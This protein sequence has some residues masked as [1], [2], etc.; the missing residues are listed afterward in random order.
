[1]NSPQLSPPIFSSKPLLI[2]LILFVLLAV[3]IRSQL[4][5]IDVVDRSAPDS[6]FS[7]QRAFDYL[8]ELTHEQLPHFVDSTNNQVVGERIIKILRQL[9]YQEEIQDQQI[10]RDSSRGLARCT[11]VK[12]ILVHIAGQDTSNGILLSAHYDSVPA[13]PGGSDAGAAVGTLL[14]IARLLRHSPKP[15]NSITL[16]FNEGEEFGLF[17]ARLFMEQHHL[18]KNIKLALNI[19][20][21]GSG[22]LSVMFETGE[23]SGWLVEHYASTTPKPLSSSLFYE[24]YKYLPNDTDLT[25][26][27]A[28]GLQ[29]LN[30]AHAEREPHYHTPLDNLENLDKGSLQHHGDN[31]W[32][33]LNALKDIDIAA[34]DSGNLVY[35]DILSMFVVSW[36]ESYSLVIASVLLLM[37][38]VLIY[39]FAKFQLFDFK[40]VAKSFLSILLVLVA[41]ALMGLLI[42]KSVV[43]FS[44]IATP[45]RSNGLSMQIAV[46]SAVGFMSLWI[47][48]WLSKNVAASSHL[49]TLATVWV[50]LT[51]LTCI[52]MP[53]ISFLFIIPASIV[54]IFLLVCINGKLDFWLPT[55][56]ICAFAAALSFLPIAYVLEIMVSY[57]LTMA[58]A[59]MVGFAVLG[60]LPTLSLQPASR[61]AVNRVNL[62]LLASMLISTSATGWWSNYTAWMPQHLN[63]TYL[64]TS[65]QDS[66]VLAGRAHENLPFELSSAL[67]DTDTDAKIPWLRARQHYA[68]Q[69]ALNI[70]DVNLEVSEVESTE[71][72]KRVQI[73]ME[74][75]PTNLV[76]VALFI[77]VDG[78][79][80]SIESYEQTLNYQ[81]ESTYYNGYYEYRCRGES[82]GNNSV[83]LNF[84]SD[85]KIKILVAKFVAGLP[86]SLQ[87]LA[88]HRGENAVP[89]QQGDQSIIVSEIEI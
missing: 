31:V 3:F 37:L 16:L 13:G 81:G 65:S 76:D 42:Q 44:P 89:R 2:S 60:L 20:A 71:G 70:P 72:E 58:I 83:T 87:Y 82:C 30:F 6:T 69:A 63:L 27:K 51:L 15:H 74:T 25:V 24:V 66:F 35:T 39:Q 84:A 64:Q 68:P 12:N 75:E 48:G 40:Q 33:V 50:L 62:V 86:P 11:R 85:K 41:A 4:E 52:T 28:H 80:V 29:G 26:F 18:A 45:W 5:T 56:I 8:Q 49:I 59:L 47:A 21:R 1:M 77:P 67:G 55:S 53:G 79:L 73:T 17:G 14:E 88:K 34:T 54:I 61:G 36:A 22:G 32:G 43:Y 78:N 46:W 9:G 19:E 23:D 7:G 38:C 10:C 57:H